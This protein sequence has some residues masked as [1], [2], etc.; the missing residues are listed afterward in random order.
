MIEI[1]FN[2]IQSFWPEITMSLTFVVAMIVEFATGR[3]G[4]S[5]TGMTTGLFVLA[6]F[7]ITILQLPFLSAEPRLLFGTMITLDP[8]AMFFKYLILAT[9]IVIIVFSMQSAEIRKQDTIGEFYCFIA[10]MTFG[11]LLMT[12][13]SNLLM[14]Y[15]SIEL[16]SISSYILAGFSKKLNRSAEAALKYVLFGGAASGF[17]LF[18]M[19]LLYGLTGALD[20]YTIQAGL[21]SGAYVH[22]SGSFYPFLLSIILIM[23]GFGY[24]ISAVPFHFWTPDVYEGAPIT[25]TAYL[26]VASKAAGFA[27]LIRFFYVTFFDSMVDVGKWVSLPHFEWNIVIAV[28]SVLTMTLGNLV[29]VWQDNLKRMLAYSSIAHAGYILMGLVVMSDLGLTA[30]LMYF[31]I[32]F[33]MNLGAFYVVMVVADRIGSEHIDD[34]RGLGKRSPVIAVGLSVF[35]VSLT[36]LPP[37]AGFVG[38]WMLFSAVVEANFIWLAIIGVINSAVSLYYYARVLRN[39]YLREP[40]NG[41]TSPI[42]FS[43]LVIV[44][45]IIFIVP[46]ILFGVYFGPLVSYAQ[47]SVQMF[48]R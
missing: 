30:M 20:I 40:L 6:G 47:H 31:L 35:L 25:V 3:K 7:T 10:A 46:N 45:T 41:D 12:G 29:A 21:A 38:K 48:L 18:G 32:Y 37:L 23:V 17:M 14:I 43:P 8:L 27:I 9:G 36:G 13:A 42:T 34:Y 11:M 19:S 4:Q 24:K 44:T 39:M 2:S 5:S 33:F 22:G 28:L 26:A 1:I 15:L 16:V